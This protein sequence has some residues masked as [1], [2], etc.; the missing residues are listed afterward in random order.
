MTVSKLEEMSDR[1]ELAH[2]RVQ[3]DFQDIN[4]VVGLSRKMR[5]IGY[6][7][8]VIMI[9]CH[10]TKR[11][12]ILLLHDDSPNTVRYQFAFLDKDPGDQYED[13]SHQELSEQMLYDWM[14]S[15]FSKTNL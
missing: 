4:P 13:I 8:D 12:I 9:D 10:S 5:D 3:K 6:D 14:V 1:I 2:Q 11:R 7:V 15:Y